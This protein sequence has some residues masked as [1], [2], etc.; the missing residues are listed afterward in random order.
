MKVNVNPLLCLK[1][2]L[3]LRETE[4]V[5]LF[6]FSIVLIVLLHGVVCEMDEWLV[7]LLLI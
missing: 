3:S 6:E 1:N 4:L 7:N 2:F 5:T